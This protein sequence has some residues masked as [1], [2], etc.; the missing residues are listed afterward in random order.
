MIAGI[1]HVQITIPKGMERE[2][3][4]FYCDLLGFIEIEK[5]LQLQKRGGLWLVVGTNE[6]HIG[7]EEGVDRTKTKAHVA[8]EVE[9]LSAVRAHLQSHNIEIIESVPI[10]N[11]DRFEIR[12]PFGNRIEFIQ[13]LQ[14]ITK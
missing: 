9:E 12:D 10:P 7:T 11:Y 13:P 4:T 14:T 8:Y 3:R 1:N 5:P 2:A 6:L